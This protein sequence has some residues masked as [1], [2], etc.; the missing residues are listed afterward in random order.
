MLS[1]TCKIA[2]ALL[3]VIAIAAG[4][5][6]PDES[7]RQTLEF[8]NNAGGGVYSLRPDGTLVVLIHP[9]ITTSQ[10]WPVNWSHP[11]G[12]IQVGQDPDTSIGTPAAPVDGVWL[13]DVWKPEL[14]NSVRYV[15][16]RDFNNPDKH[17]R[18]DLKPPSQAP[19]TRLKIT[20]GAP[21]D[22]CIAPPPAFPLV[23]K[24][25]VTC[26]DFEYLRSKIPSV[27]W[28]PGTQLQ[29]MVKVRRGDRVVVTMDS[30]EE[31]NGKFGPDIGGLRHA[32]VVM[33]D[34]HREAIRSVEIMEVM[35]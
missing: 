8:K 35:R 33:P 31:F 5:P 11:I 28:P 19:E 34:I 23:E 9:T 2:A 32:L 18:I 15:Y 13:Q 30:G 7:A 16:V 14:G 27:P 25:E 29:L 22:V 3:L 10:D 1:M 24:I 12:F 21:G 26:L 4:Q 17:A 6:P 20:A